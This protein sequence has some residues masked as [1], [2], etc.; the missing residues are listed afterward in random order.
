[1]KLTIVARKGCPVR[2]RGVI[3]PSQAAAARALSL[4]P[5]T[6]ANALDAGRVDEVGLG[7]RRGGHPGKPCIY[8]GKAY[9]SRKA[10]ALA[11][12]V[13]IAAVSKAARSNDDMR[14][15]AA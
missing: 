4:N 8:R 5:L 10:A 6:I 1:M 3:Y 15:W 14:R 7:I 2:I 11:C 12:G 9:P 13:S